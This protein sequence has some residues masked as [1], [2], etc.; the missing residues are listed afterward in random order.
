[1]SK[2]CATGDYRVPPVMR[3]FQLLRYIGDGHDCSN[4]QQVSR[5]LGISRTTLIRLLQTLKDEGAIERLA[6]GQGYRLGISLVSLASRAL[7]ERDLVA[8]ALPVLR[9]LSDAQGLSAYLGIR[10]GD[11]SLYLARQT[12]ERSLVSN[13]RVGSRL[14]LPATSIGRILLAHL[15]PA[16]VSQLVPEARLDE[17]SAGLFHDPEA[18]QAA[19]RQDRAANLSWSA[20]HYET[21]V[22]SCAA[23]LRDAGGEVVGAINLVGARPLFEVGHPRRSELADALG[24]A[25]GRISA[26]LGYSGIG[27]GGVS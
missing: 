27:S 26:E 15:D 1:M 20:G 21:D 11:S 3:A 23:A 6:D 10:D 9:A 2:S 8:V 16:Q 14:P 7:Q 18:L 5:A 25:A 24:R 19:L 13:I 4:V 12:P 22:G 17:L